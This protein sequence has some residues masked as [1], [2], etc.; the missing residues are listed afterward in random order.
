MAGRTDCADGRPV[1][2]YMMLYELALYDY[3]T[4]VR[5][6][7]RTDCADGRPDGWPLF[8]D[9][10]TK[11]FYIYFGNGLGRPLFADKR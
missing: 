11:A 4:M 6:G 3:D 7:V 1:G 9:T 8:S 10:Q 5:R 2:F